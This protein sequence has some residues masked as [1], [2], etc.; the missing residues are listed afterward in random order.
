MS[1]CYF[2]RT[3]I[4]PGIEVCF[5]FCFFFHLVMQSMSKEQS[6]KTGDAICSLVCWV[7]SRSHIFA[8]SYVGNSF[9]VIINSPTAPIP[10]VVSAFASGPLHCRVWVWLRAY[11]SPS[12]WSACPLQLMAVCS[13]VSRYLCQRCFDRSVYPPSPAWV[14][15]CRVDIRV[16][17]EGLSLA[18]SGLWAS[19][20]GLAEVTEGTSSIR[21]DFKC[22]FAP[23]LG[24][25]FLNY[26]WRS[27][28]Q[29]CP[30]FHLSIF[31][32]EGAMVQFCGIWW[33]SHRMP[34]VFMGDLCL[35]FSPFLVVGCSVVDF[36]SQR[37]PCGVWLPFRPL[38]WPFL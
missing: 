9:L 19:S 23:A 24:A 11:M 18:W 2:H 17:D 25:H 30:S 29:W 28:S 14:C 33:P 20:E 37:A 5:V 27:L 12:V 3:D 22:W 38:S 35:F 1:K 21:Y 15:S 6:I 13:V 10:L 7:N 8:A 4:L 31:L 32:F 36:S 34:F 26:R 16:D